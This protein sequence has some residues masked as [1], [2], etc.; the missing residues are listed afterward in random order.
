[1]FKLLA[2]LL[3]FIL[4]PLSQAQTPL[5]YSLNKGDKFV[6]QQ[7]ARQLIIQEFEGYTHEL[8]NNMDG[9]MEFHVTNVEHDLYKIEMVYLD[10]GMNL[11]SSVQGEITNIRASQ[12]IEDDVQSRIFNSLIG[13]PVQIVLNKSGHVLEVNGGEHLIEKMTE[14]SGITDSISRQALRISLRDEFGSEAL[15][16]SFEQMTYIYPENDTITV[17]WENEYKGKLFAKNTWTLQKTT[18]SLNHIS[19]KADITVEI[20]DIGT[21]MLLYG[22]QETTLTTDARNGVI[23]NM[24]VEGFSKGTTMTEFSG[25]A[26]IPTTVSSTT[27]YKLIQH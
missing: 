14:A 1:M 13:V 15:S 12:L 6:I 7:D 4:C 22:Q 20:N 3:F 18:D 26:E 9:L 10:L 5:S 25:D 2:G 21:S 11:I 8:E 23:K 24:L 27:T 19:G 17:H 16:S